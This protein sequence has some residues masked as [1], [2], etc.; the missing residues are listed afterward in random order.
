VIVAYIDG[1]KAR[2]G[3]EPIC[4]VLSAHGMQ[5]AP[6]TYHAAVRLPVSAADLADAYLAN[7]LVDLF[8][9]NRS[10]YGVRKLWHAARRAGHDVGRDQVGRLMRIVGIAGVVRGTRSTTTTVRAA[11]SAPRHPDLIERAWNTPTRPG[12]WWV[13][14]FTYVWTLAG[15]CYVALLTDVYSRRI[16]GW[17][18]TTSKTTPLVLSALEQASFARRRTSFEFTA[19]GLVHHSDAGAQYTSIAF[20]DALLDAGIAG[21]IGSVGD[22]LDN[23]LMESTIG[24]YKTELID[25][26]PRSWTGRAEVERETASWVHWYNTARLHSS[27][28]YLPPTE[29]EQHYHQRTTPAASIPDVA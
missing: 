25:R 18:V 1:H 2:F 8:G 9:V 6:S 13:A 29:Y 14:D 3:I 15:F 19:E 10:V 28:G 20:T 5:I 24:V 23:A 7:A 17:R 21:S 4:R 27:I 22:A 12:Q 11:R 16:L 26:H